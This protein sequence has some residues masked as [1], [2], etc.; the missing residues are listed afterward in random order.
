ME[1]LK[2][3]IDKQELITYHR[4]GNSEVTNVM[5]GMTKMDNDC[6]LILDDPN[7]DI[8]NFL[9]RPVD[10]ANF[11]WVVG[12]NQNDQLVQPLNFPEL[13]LSKRQYAQKMSGF[14]GFKATLCLRVLANP[15]K[16]QQGIMI[17]H[18]IP[19]AK[20]IPDRV[21]LINASLSG[22]T[23]CGH[24]LFSAESDSSKTLKIPYVNQNNMM[25][26]ITG[27]GNFGSF[28]VSIFTPLV[29]TDNISVGVKVQAWF[30]NIELKY[31]TS[32]FLEPDARYV[33]ESSEDVD[34]V[35]SLDM[36][37]SHDTALKDVLKPSYL[38]GTAAN[39]LQLAGYQKSLN[40]EKRHPVQ[41]NVATNMA[42][43]NGEFHGAQ[44][45]LAANNMLKMTKNPAAN[46]HDE[47]NI[48]HVVSKPT[49]FDTFFMK[50]SDTRRKKI[51]SV[52][53]QPAIFKPFKDKYLI[54]TTLGFVSSAF[55]QWRGTIDYTFVVT[56][57]TFHSG[58][59]RATWLPYCYPTSDSDFANLNLEMG[60]QQ[61]FDLKD[62]SSFNVAI[63]Y[64]GTTPFMTCINPY[65]PLIDSVPL[66]YRSTGTLVI[67]VFIPLRAPTT[68]SDSI[69]LCVFAA[70]VNDFEL[71]CPT[72]P[73]IF[74]SMP[75]ITE[76]FMTQS[77]EETIDC[78]DRN[79]SSSGLIG[80]TIRCD[81]ALPSAS[82]LGEQI[83]SI[84][85]LLS[86]F[87]PF[88][89]L[90]AKEDL[91]TILA[92]F[93]VCLDSGG[94]ITFDY[95][96]YFSYLYA[97]FH[98]GVRLIVDMQLLKMGNNVEVRMKNDVSNFY[99]Q[100]FQRCAQSP[101][102]EKEYYQNQLSAS[103]FS[104]QVLKTDLQGVVAIQ[105]PYHAK[106]NI[107]PVMIRDVGRNE[108]IRA[109]TTSSFVEIVATPVNATV[110]SPSVYRACADDFRFFY[111]L[112][113]PIVRMLNT[114]IIIPALVFDYDILNKLSEIQISPEIL[115]LD[116]TRY[117]WDIFYP[118]PYQFPIIDES[119][120]NLMMIPKY[121]KIKFQKTDGTITVY[122]ENLNLT[123][124]LI[125]SIQR[126]NPKTATKFTAFSKT[127]IQSEG[128]ASPNNLY[129]AVQSEVSYVIKNP[130]VKWDVINFVDKGEF[131]TSLK[132]LPVV[133][134][135]LNF[136]TV[137]PMAKVTFFADG[138]VQSSPNPGFFIDTIFKIK[139]A[140]GK[141]V[142]NVYF[143]VAKVN[144]NREDEGWEI[145]P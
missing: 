97:F 132:P 20:N 10:V 142:S 99:P 21:Q 40:I 62:T 114:S 78:T 52:Q 121:A 7:H 144:V 54:P 45:A 15:Q 104:T 75:P 36:S 60:Y 122:C 49:Y 81:S 30:E 8:K 93:D 14:V 32:N 127:N 117:N 2:I 63:P 100:T 134:A 87:G 112:G 94:V 56:K 101:L 50:T 116:D 38:V 125:A 82:C 107:C 46:S 53:V 28:Y 43:F 88:C 58:S 61:T 64:T 71:A 113:P 120:T 119:Q 66:E 76:R 27:D 129:N 84:K 145:C 51:W 68:V 141:L 138:S 67:D 118:A 106:T 95:I 11:S 92:P 131:Y 6:T 39:F 57:T 18:W 47:M 128:K 73:T 124:C 111:Q 31:P 5:P 37:R 74:P 16:F 35:G 4:Q 55:T 86:R 44:M 140:A 135:K 77:S 143:G 42:N 19:N 13:L 110:S 24:I 34:F 109:I 96:D 91:V 1:N 136:A 89:R 102:T 3:T 139:Y 59:I 123:G 90:P 79:E 17:A 108:V 98:G 69:Q 115:I 22:K 105:V 25:N 12:G 23:G 126:S 133:T 85:N 70:G 9:A 72:P 65:S 33:T 29:S 48:G 130:A 26:L 83:V 103:P 41:L 137:K 80:G